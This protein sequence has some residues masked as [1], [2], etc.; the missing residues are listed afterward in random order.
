MNN[1]NLT[2]GVVGYGAFGQ[3]MARLLSEH[4]KVSVYSRRT[5]AGIEFSNNI[6]A[7]TLADIAKCDVI[8]LCN[9]LHALEENA[10]ALAKLVKPSTIV[11]DVCSV[12]VIPAQILKSTLSGHCKVLATHPL[13]GPQS[14]PIGKNHGKKIVWHEIS[15]GPF[16]EL[17]AFFTNKLGLG[18]IK[19]SPEEHDKQMA[20]VHC[21][22]F[23]VGRGLMELNPPESKLSTNYYEHLLSVVE[24]EKQHSYE[25]FRTIQVGNM[26]SSQIRKELIQRLTEIDQNL[27]KD[28]I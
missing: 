2:F 21:L 10:T 4:S 3:L 27:Q 13:F 19:M 11:M 23:F 6:N 28:Y 22:T 17:E 7:G 1:E 8:L 15:G 14:A 26:Y 12:K 20:W 5:I 25:L 16:D 18:I 24:L 9:E